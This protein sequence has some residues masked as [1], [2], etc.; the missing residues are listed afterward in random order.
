MTQVATAERTHP[1]DHVSMVCKCGVLVPTLCG[2]HSGA[3]GRAFSLAKYNVDLLAY[4]KFE[5]HKISEFELTTHSKY[6]VRLDITMPS[7]RSVLVDPTV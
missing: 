6:V 7:K 2:S 5:Y 3:P 1:K 4:H